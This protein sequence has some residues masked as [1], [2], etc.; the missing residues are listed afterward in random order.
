[1][2]APTPL[3]DSQAPGLDVTLPTPTR[4]AIFRPARSSWQ[5][6]GRLLME[7]VLVP[8]VFILHRR[9]GD[10]RAFLHW[11]EAEPRYPLQQT[12]TVSGGNR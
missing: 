3:V 1:M 12:E 5:S 6:V 4:R 8:Y 9:K 7:Q 10:L 2:E 11:A